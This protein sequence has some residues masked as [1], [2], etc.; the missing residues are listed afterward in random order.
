MA[1]VN[2]LISR[3]NARAKRPK[4]DCR[5]CTGEFSIREHGGRI[6]GNVVNLEHIFYKNNE[7]KKIRS[8]YARLQEIK[9]KR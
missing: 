6:W 2:L 3:Y 1:S 8:L 4:R 5:F 7:K 9:F